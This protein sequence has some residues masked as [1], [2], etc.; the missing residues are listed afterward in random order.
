MGKKTIIVLHESVKQ[1]WLRDAGTLLTFVAM[2]VFAEWMDSAAGRNVCI[3]LFFLLLFA[4]IKV[5]D[6][7]TPSEARKR[8]DQIERE[9]MGK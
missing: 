4:K 1:S 6:P 7:M 3:A 8:I 2:V 9:E 5:S